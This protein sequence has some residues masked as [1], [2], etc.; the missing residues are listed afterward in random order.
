MKFALVGSGAGAEIGAPQITKPPSALNV[1]RKFTG[2]PLNESGTFWLTKLLMSVAYVGALTCGVLFLIVL[3]G[4]GNV[5][6]FTCVYGKM[7]GSSRLISAAP[8]PAQS[9]MTC[10][11]TAQPEPCHDFASREA[12]LATDI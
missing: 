9:W 10:R 2:W 11:W 4:A 12:R 8:W 7:S 1:C 6:P 3:S 5:L